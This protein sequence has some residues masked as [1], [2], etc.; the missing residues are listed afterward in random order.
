MF[1]VHKLNSLKPVDQIGLSYIWRLECSAQIS[2][3]HKRYA[4]NNREFC[5]WQCGKSKLMLRSVCFF[6]FQTI[7]NWLEIMIFPCKGE[8]YNSQHTLRSYVF[9]SPSKWREFIW[10]EIYQMKRNA[11]R[12]KLQK[13]YWQAMLRTKPILT[14]NLLTHVRRW[15]LLNMILSCIH[16]GKGHALAFILIRIQFYKFLNRFWM[17]AYE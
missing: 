13:L 7:T 14:Q 16:T 11:R 6:F 1:I 17:I 8:V 3:C 9:T 15:V 12:T 4:V 5:Y 10:R 2:S